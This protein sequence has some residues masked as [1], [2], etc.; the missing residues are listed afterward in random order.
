MCFSRDPKSTRASDK[1]VREKARRLALLDLAVPKESPF[2][3]V[4]RAFF[5]PDE[6]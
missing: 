2:D 1:D 4:E 5:I 3:D 6:P